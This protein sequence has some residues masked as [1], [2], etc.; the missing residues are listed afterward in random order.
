MEKNIFVSE[1]PFENGGI[2]I[3]VGEKLRMK[4]EILTN[5]YHIFSKQ[6]LDLEKENIDGK[7]ELEVSKKSK[8]VMQILQCLFS[9][10]EVYSEKSYE[11]LTQVIAIIYP[12]RKILFVPYIKCEG[13]YQ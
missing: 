4:A 6:L 2:P 7:Y 1:E 8:E 3:T 13:I 11:E 10:K 5:L 9:L 12:D